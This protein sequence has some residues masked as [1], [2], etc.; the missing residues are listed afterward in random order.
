MKKF[1]DDNGIEKNK[2]IFLIIITILAGV[3]CACGNSDALNMLSIDGI[4]NHVGIQSGKSD[5]SDSVDLEADSTLGLTE[6]PDPEPTETPSPEPTE[7]PTPEPTETPTPEP[8]ETPTPVPTITPTKKPEPVVT[9][10]PTEAPKP[11]VSPEPTKALSFYEDALAGDCFIGDSRT[12]ELFY[13][14]GVSTAD[15]LYKTGLNVKAALDENLIMEPLSRN[16]YRN[17]YIEFGVNELGWYNLDY[18]EDCYVELINRVRELQP[19]ATIYVQSIIPVSQHLSDNSSIETLANV[20]KFNKRVINAANRTGAVY[21]DVTI[22]ICGESR[23]LPPDASY[24]G[25]HPN[26]KYVLKWLDYVIE[27]R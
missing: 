4:H 18:F 7:T 25:V 20:E 11:T 24:D 10:K 21:L 14:T 15:F 13:L 16:K 17:I 5:N 9:V 19:D 26:R 22:G 8:T 2:I 1:K 3:F 27:N 23:V 12:E 6:T